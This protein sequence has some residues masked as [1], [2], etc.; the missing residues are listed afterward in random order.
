MRRKS[1]QDVPCGIAR[2][3]D[4]LDDAWTFQIIRESLFGLTAF[5]DFAEALDI[6]RN[7]LSR[8]LDSLVKNGLMSKSSDKKDGR[9]KIYRLEEAGRDLW[10]VLLALQQWGN[11]WQFGE[12][13]APSF[14][15]DQKFPHP[16]IRLEA[17]GVDGRKVTLNDV[18]MAPG[19]SAT[20]ALKARFRALGL[21][22]IG[23]APINAT[24]N[25]LKR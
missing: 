12:K 20:A 16:S 8:K 17:T 25:R 3:M 11:K 24:S 7:T 22:L 19:P 10:I 9:R 13:G 2:A 4:A 15:I 6:P 5:D 14:M 23:H 18:T 21:S 1:F